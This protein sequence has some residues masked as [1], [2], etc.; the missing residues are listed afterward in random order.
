MLD[1][2]IQPFSEFDFMQRALVG[3]FVISLGATPIG[4]FLL[5][6]GMSLSGDAISH[7]ML[8]GVALAYSIYG[9]SLVAMSLGGFIV[10]LGVV[11]GAGLVSRKTH[12]KEDA[13]LA[14]FYLIS[15]AIGVIIITIKGSTLDLMHILFGQ[16]LALD[17]ASIILLGTI[18]SATLI[19]LAFFYRAFVFE[20]FDKDFFASVS[21]SGNFIYY[22]FLTLVVLNFV[23]GFQ[24]LGTLMV[25]SIM[26]LPAASARFWTINLG[27]SFALA[28]SLAILSGYSGL[29]I[30]YYYSIATG[31]AIVLILGFLYFLSF[32]FGKHKSFLSGA[33]KRR[34]KV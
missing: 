11:V 8:P 27:T 20:C 22:F 3:I 28:F 29:L 1:L 5:L 12:L 10:G 17:D 33:K 30:S 18:A 19:S 16:V 7:T 6:R 21:K 2:L 15:L 9:V 32:L 24:A 34:K 26:I 4:I 31:P 13:T 25:V 23:A 14:A